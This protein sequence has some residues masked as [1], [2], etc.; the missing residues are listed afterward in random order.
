MSTTTLQKAIHDILKQQ[1]EAAIKN[2]DK[3]LEI[4][5]PK[6]VLKIKAGAPIKS[7]DYKDG[8]AI[9]KVSAHGVVIHNKTRPRLT[10][11]LEKGH[12]GKN[13]AGTW[14]RVKAFPHIGPAEQEGV[15]EFLELLQSMPLD[16]DGPN[17]Y[18][19]EV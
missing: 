7:G 13:Q 3:A 14:G 11:L 15:R 16:A 17:D 10:H 6:V 5:P 9:K 1:E 8:W 18:K 19:V 2:L 12:V 4:V